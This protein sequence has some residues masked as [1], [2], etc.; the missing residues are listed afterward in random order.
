MILSHSVFGIIAMSYFKGKM[1]Y[2]THLQ[3]ESVIINTKWECLNEGGLWENRLYNFDNISN[4]LI[5]LFVMSTTAGW[6][7]VVVQT[8]SGIE[9]DEQGLETVRPA[10]WTLFFMCFMI[11]AHFFFL[12]LF[13]VVVI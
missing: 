10:A 13:V 9:I 1:H 8:I 4:S 12:N 7:D 5:S 11:V 2:C 3:E 6:S